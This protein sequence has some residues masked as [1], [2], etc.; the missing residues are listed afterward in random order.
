MYIILCTKSQTKLLYK[1]LP[2]EFLSDISGN[3]RK[4]IRSTPETQ[5]INQKDQENYA[6]PSGMS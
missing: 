5:L 1:H 3:N 6:W 2:P 4:N